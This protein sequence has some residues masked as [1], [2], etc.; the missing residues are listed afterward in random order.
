MDKTIL[1]VGFLLALKHAIADGPLQTSY[2][3]MNKGKLHHPGGY[4]HA[5]IHGAGTAIVLAPFGLW[6][7]GVVD[8]L[9]HFLIDLA[10]VR[11]T[12]RYMWSYYNSHGYL[13]VTNNNFFNAI[14]VDQAMHFATYVVFLSLL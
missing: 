10:K 1:V 11:T 9:A 2:Q 12:L 4:L 3:Y 7:L 14:V 13:A 5:G 6:W 8:A